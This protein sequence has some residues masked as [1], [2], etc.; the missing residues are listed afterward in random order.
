LSTVVVVH[1]PAHNWWF[2]FGR[3]QVLWRK[4]FTT[5]HWTGLPD[6]EGNEFC[7]GLFG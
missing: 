3:R 4:Y 5:H 2:G 6:P 1:R 7:A